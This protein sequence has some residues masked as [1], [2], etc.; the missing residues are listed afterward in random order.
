M[1]YFELKADPDLSNPIQIQ[2]IDVQVY[3]DGISKECFDAIKRLHVAYFDHSEQTE[4]CDALYKP[5]FMISDALRS[6]FALYE[7]KMELKGVQLFA[8]NMDDNTAPLY[9]MPYIEPVV[10]LGGESR[11]YPNGML[12]KLVLDRNASIENRHIFR[13]AEILEYKIIVSLPVAESILRRQMTG[14]SFEPIAFSDTGKEEALCQ[15]KSI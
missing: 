3:K 13:V 7:P 14:I 15:T 8:N 10:C 6:V 12:E 5:A 11:K 1:K 9:W 2:K 4:I